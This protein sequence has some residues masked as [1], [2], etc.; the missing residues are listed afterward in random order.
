MT[1]FFF[2]HFPY[3]Y[4]FTRKKR[5]GKKK[6]KVPIQLSNLLLIIQSIPFF[7]SSHFI[8]CPT[9]LPNAAF[10]PPSRLTRASGHSIQ[11][12]APPPR[13]LHISVRHPILISLLSISLER[14]CLSIYQSLNFLI[15]IYQSSKCLSEGAREGT[16]LQNIPLLEFPPPQYTYK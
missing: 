10:P 16:V 15:N 4:Y 6:K 11:R 12:I 13:P 5:G 3:V 7:P 2:H 9:F 8:P 1:R 14:P